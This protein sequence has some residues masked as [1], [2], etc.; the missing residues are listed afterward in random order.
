MLLGLSKGM[1]MPKAVFSISP[2]ES[3]R[4]PD[5][6]KAESPTALTAENLHK[7]LR[8]N[9]KTPHDRRIGTLPDVQ[10]LHKPKAVSG[11]QGFDE[12]LVNLCGSDSSKLGSAFSEMLLLLV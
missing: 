11:R 4:C 9:G 10:S 8:R 1:S 5:E 2:V 12:Q 3:P 6:G 7:E